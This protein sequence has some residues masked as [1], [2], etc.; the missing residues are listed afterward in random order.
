MLRAAIRGCTPASTAKSITFDV[1]L[2]SPTAEVYLDYDKFRQIMSNLLGNAIKFTAQGGR[3]VVSCEM[4]N[5]GGMM[6]SVKD[7]GIGIKPQDIARI[8]EPF[9]QVD[10]GHTSQLGAG[11]GLP[12]AKQLTEAHGGRL[13]VESIFGEGTTVIVS[14][15]PG[16]VRCPSA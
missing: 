8:M 4:T 5:E 14:L 12:I 13:Q 6:L 10:R 7:T 15:P 11:L 1:L 3:I 2:S 9:V 16:T